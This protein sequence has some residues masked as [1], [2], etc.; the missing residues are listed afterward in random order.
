M[1]SICSKW[2]IS[3]SA[4]STPFFAW[5]N[6][7]LD[8]SF[9]RTFGS[10]GYVHIPAVERQK[11]DQKSVKCIF[12]GYSLTQKAYRF[13]DPTSRKI[14]ISRDVTFDENDQPGDFLYSSS[15]KSTHVQPDEGEY[16]ILFPEHIEN[17]APAAIN[18]PAEPEKIEDQSG[19]EPLVDQLVATH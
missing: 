4:P 11:L 16:G 18:H 7:K 6:S 5:Y 17:Q 1:C 19:P 3:K 13:W 9:L 12:V 10:T 8:V 14:R 15:D 2:T